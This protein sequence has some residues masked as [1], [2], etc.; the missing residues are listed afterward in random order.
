[1]APSAVAVV[2]CL[3]APAP[4]SACFGGV[5]AVTPPAWK[6]AEVCCMWALTLNTILYLGSRATNNLGETDPSQIIALVV[7]H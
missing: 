4:V 3:F 7:N 1:M 2:P 6:V 5:A